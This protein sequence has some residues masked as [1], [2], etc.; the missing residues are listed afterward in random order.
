MRLLV[1]SGRPESVEA[2]EPCG[3]SDQSCLTAGLAAFAALGEHAQSC[4]VWGST[5]L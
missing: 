2:G 3:Q 4:W 5:Q 1:W